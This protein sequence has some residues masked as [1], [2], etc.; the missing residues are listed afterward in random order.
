[1]RIKVRAQ[2]KMHRS[3]IFLLPRNVA[4]NRICAYVQNLGIERGELLPGGVERRQLR[5]SSGCP[6]QR[7]KCQ[8]D[9]LLATKIAEP[10]VRILP[11]SL[12]AAIRRQAHLRPTCSCPPRLQPVGR[13][14]ACLLLA[15]P[16]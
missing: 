1:M 13:R 4:E 6:V 2:R 12:R 7:M 15:A 8:N 3:D 16:K 10:Q 11:T 14:W 5:R 9:V